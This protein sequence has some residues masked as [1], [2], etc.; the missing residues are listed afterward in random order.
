M[1][2]P[3]PGDEVRAG[4]DIDGDCGS[5]ISEGVRG[6]VDAVHHH[7]LGP[8][9]A[10]ITFER[11]G[12]FGRDR[13]VRDVPLEDV[14]RS[15][16][17]IPYQPSGTPTR[18]RHRTSRAPASSSG[19]ISGGGGGVSLGDDAATELTMIGIGALVLV[20]TGWA[21]S[22]AAGEYLW[23]PLFAGGAVPGPELDDVALLG[24][25]GIV[26]LTAAALAFWRFGVLGRALLALPLLLAGGHVLINEAAE[27]R[28]ALTRAQAAQSVQADSE[29]AQGTA[30]LASAAL[31]CFPRKNYNAIVLGQQGFPCDRLRYPAPDPR[32]GSEPYDAG[33]FFISP[34]TL[35]F[36]EAEARNVLFGCAT[37]D[38]PIDMRDQ[39]RVEEY[40]KTRFGTTAYT[41]PGDVIR[42]E[43]DV[44]PDTLR[45]GTYHGED[46]I[47]S[48]TW[49]LPP[50]R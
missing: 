9:R 16:P 3:E 49:T 21:L 40:S 17:L 32:T 42:C 6:R 48:R 30:L 14:H 46:P 10:D 15:H 33:H 22:W 45:P 24:G 34:L 23:R 7:L 4:K 13:Q 39:F 19:G 47:P 35:T 5:E 36:E 50:V 20:L 25:F 1:R 27:Q 44:E 12:L 38:D 41:S 28:T 18:E 43:L 11:D 2:Q 26:L 37:N 8:D 29:I 31:E